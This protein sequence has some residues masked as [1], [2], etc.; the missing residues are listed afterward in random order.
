MA[1]EATGARVEFGQPLNASTPEALLD[2]VRDTGAEE[3][4]LAVY[5][6]QFASEGKCQLNTYGV[7]IQWADIYSLLGTV[8]H[9]GTIQLLGLPSIGPLRPILSS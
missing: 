3:S 7:C 5:L 1:E 9:W 8:E 4:I 2:A 6:A